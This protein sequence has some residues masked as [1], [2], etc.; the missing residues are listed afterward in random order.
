MALSRLGN[1][2]HATVTSKALFFTNCFQG[3]VVGQ[4]NTTDNSP[5]RGLAMVRKGGEKRL[6]IIYHQPAFKPANIEIRDP[7]DLSKATTAY[8]ATTKPAEEICA[9]PKG[10]IMLNTDKSPKFK[11]LTELFW[12]SEDSWKLKTRPDVSAPLTV[13]TD[14]KNPLGV[15]FGLGSMQP[16]KSGDDLTLLCIA[17]YSSLA[18]YALQATGSGRETWTL[19][20]GPPNH[21]LSEGLLRYPCDICPFGTRTCLVAD[22]SLNNVTMFNVE[23]KGSFMKALAGE[24]EHLDKPRSVGF[25]SSKSTLAVLNKEGA[26]IRLYQVK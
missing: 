17:S 18:A 24:R 19:R 13:T 22:Q 3:N 16:V 8:N 12:A 4:C 23:G 15:V 5:V 6:A 20:A 11:C 14:D 7:R 2:G 21:R 1:P 9:T 26:E 25:I 10:M